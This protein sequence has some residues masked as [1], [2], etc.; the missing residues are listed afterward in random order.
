MTDKEKRKLLMDEFGQN[1]ADLVQISDGH[2][3]DHAKD[4]EATAAKIEESGATPLPC[5]EMDASHRKFS[6]SLQVRGMMAN[7]IDEEDPERGIKLK[8]LID[9]WDKSTSA[10]IEEKIA[11]A[12][13]ACTSIGPSVKPK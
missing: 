2:L 6:T 7:L 1:I 11:P 9:E 13:A 4:L 12:L 5:E 8:P 10:T 3:A